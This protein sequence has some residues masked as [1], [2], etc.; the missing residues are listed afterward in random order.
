[1]SSVLA[2]T[3]TINHVLSPWKN[4]HSKACPKSL[5]KP[6]QQTMSSV[7]AK[8]TTKHY[9]LRPYTNQT[10]SSVLEKTTSTEHALSPCK[11]IHYRTYPQFLHNPPLQNMP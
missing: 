2:K 1:M 4:N 9:V 11:N 5:Q 8:T 10:I 3:T 7:L 6:P